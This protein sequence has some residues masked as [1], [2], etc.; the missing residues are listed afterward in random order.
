MKNADVQIHNIISLNSCNLLSSI[1]A[2][3][4]EYRVITRRPISAPFFLSGRRVCVPL[5]PPYSIFTIFKYVVSQ[6]KKGAIR[7]RRAIINAQIYCTR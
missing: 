4:T 7:E 5:L 3:V 2:I 1:K 6:Y